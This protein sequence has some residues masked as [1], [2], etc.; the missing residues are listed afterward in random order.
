MASKFY[1]GGH[2]KQFEKMKLQTQVNYI[3][4]HIYAAFVC[5]LWD[6][7][8][9]RE[10]IQT[11]FNNTWDRWKDSTEN[12]WDILQNVIDVTGIDVMMEVSKRR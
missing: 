1:G 4:P 6:L 12:G 10:E 7:G 3:V 11:L 5:E 8:W 9:S 2:K